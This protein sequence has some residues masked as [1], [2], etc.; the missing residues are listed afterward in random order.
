MSEF[1]EH[2][3]LHPFHLDV[4]G[5]R[6]PN[7]SSVPGE[8]KVL[9]CTDPVGMAQKSTGHL[10]VGWAFAFVQR[11]GGEGKGTGRGVCPWMGGE[12]ALGHSRG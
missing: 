2:M 6:N 4:K 5:P 9:T 1:S 11:E 7:F 8:P 3:P 12:G 10:G